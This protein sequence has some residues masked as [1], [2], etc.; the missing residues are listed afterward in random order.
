MANM[1]FYMTPGTC[2]TGVHIL[3]E[4]LALIFEAYVV[5]LP[6]GEQY[7]PEYLAINPKGTIP[8]LVTPNGT[9][10]TE[11]TAIAYWLSHS[12]PKAGLWPDDL[13]LQ[14]KVIETMNYIVGTIHLQGY[15]R[16]FTPEQYTFVQAD[17]ARIKAQ[18]E[19]IVKKGFAILDRQL[20]GHEYL[21]GDFSIADAAL[22]YV[23]FW[24]D[25]IDIALPEYCLAHYRRMLKRPAVQ[26]VLREEGYNPNQLGKRQ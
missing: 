16:I 15:T 26:Q 7:K 2:S 4:E 9:S 8:T 13:L 22:F 18:G 17:G 10:I 14:T 12:Y 21:A 11:F 19:T 6:A 24:A 20:A 1:K 25:K 3:L 5:N 23:S